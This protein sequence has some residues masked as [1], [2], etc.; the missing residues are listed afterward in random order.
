MG[1]LYYL[2][3]FDEEASYENYRQA[4]G[5][6]LFSSRQLAED[7]AKRYLAKVTG[8]KDYPVTYQIEEKRVPGAG[9]DLPSFVFLVSGWNENDDLDEIDV[10]ESDCYRTEKEA[11]RAL[12]AL[13]SACPRQ[14]W[15]INRWTIDQCNWQEGFD[16]YTY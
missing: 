3:M 4:F 14:H 15:C 11:E 13:K 16:R 1:T 12:E 5:I 8:F 2:Q 6:G 9:G 7:T 10:I